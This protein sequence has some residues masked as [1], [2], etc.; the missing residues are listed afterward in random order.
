MLVATIDYARV[1]YYSVTLTNC[2]RNG[3]LYGRR[4]PADPQSPYASLQDAALADATDLQPA[5]VVTSTTGVDT[6]GQSFIEVTA[7]YN[8]E[9]FAK[10]PG[11]PSAVSLGRTIRMPLAPI[12]PGT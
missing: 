6:N 7:S 12:S 8:F 4:S 9:T 1:F 2:A 10:Y 11:I 3:A 5:P